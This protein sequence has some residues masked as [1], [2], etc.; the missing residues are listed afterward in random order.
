MMN[1]VGFHVFDGV[2]FSRLHA[3]NLTLSDTLA[4]NGKTLDILL[5][6]SRLMYLL[7]IINLVVCRLHSSSNAP[8]AR[9]LSVCLCVNIRCHRER[10]L[11]V[12]LIR[13]QRSLEAWNARRSLRHL[14]VVDL[15]TRATLGLR[16]LSWHSSV[17]RALRKWVVTSI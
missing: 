2:M 4:T 9:S 15:S 17:T 6:F 5:G 11:L 16:R 10:L 7:H 8:E 14:R 12:D 1:R 3:I 13:V